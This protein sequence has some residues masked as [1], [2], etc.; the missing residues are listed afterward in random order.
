[1]PQ[2][3]DQ[4]KSCPFCGGNPTVD[5]QFGREWWVECDDCAATTGG[6]EATKAEAID[7]WNRRA[8]PLVA[9]AP[10]E[11]P[12]PEGWATEALEAIWN[13]PIGTTITA[14]M[15]RA[16]SL[17]LRVARGEHWDDASREWVAPPAS[18]DGEVVVTKNQAGQIVA[19]TRQDEDHRILSIIAESAPA[20]LAP[21][22]EEWLKE[23]EDL[24][25]KYG[26]LEYSYGSACETTHLST[27]EIAKIGDGSDE[28]RAALLSHLRTA[29]RPALSDEQIIA[30]ALP[31]AVGGPHADTL[32]FARAVLASVAPKEPEQP[33]T[34]QPH[35][36]APLESAVQG[37]DAAAGVP[38]SWKPAM[39]KHPDCAEACQ[40]AVDYG[41]WDQHCCSPECVRLKRHPAG[42]QEV[43]HG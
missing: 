39:P 10:R 24:I 25:R 4:L 1:M 16:A 22:P 40:K 13:A 5:A 31:F 41:V 30:K 14:D 17:A 35:L 36:A 37:L 18:L 19:V 27:A 32:A 26:G 11:P 9:E 33:N 34:E 20:S 6:M 8:V 23:A 15:K 29:P 3:T 21:M 2:T 12:L 38:G 7:A 42:A 43:P 28:A